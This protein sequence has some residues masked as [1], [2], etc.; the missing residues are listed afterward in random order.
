[1]SGGDPSRLQTAV[2]SLGPQTVF[3]SCSPDRGSLGSLPVRTWVLQD[4]DSSLV[5]LF[6]LNYPPKG[7]SPDRVT[8]E[9]Q[10]EC[11]TPDS[12]H[13]TGGSE[14]LMGK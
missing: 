6:H 9:V 4:L 5:T 11:D 3:S 2:F 10:E 8:S 13:P 14:F 7:P 12:F 1:M